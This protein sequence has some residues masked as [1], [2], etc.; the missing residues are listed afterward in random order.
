MGLRDESDFSK[1]LFSFL[2]RLTLSATK[3]IPDATKPKAGLNSKGT[4]LA[5]LTENVE[6]L[7]EIP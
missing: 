7:R 4:A 5:D 6:L 2:V 3:N 1:T